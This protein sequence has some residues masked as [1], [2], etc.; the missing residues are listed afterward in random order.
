MS[1]L[2]L[3]ADF[4]EKLLKFGL[5]GL[6]GVLVDF[7]FTWLCKEKLKLH[8]YLANSIGFCMATASNYLL[9]RY[10]TFSVPGQ[11]A[12]FLEFSKFFIIALIGLGLNNVI[13]FLIHEKLKVNFYLAKAIAIGVVAIWNF[14]GNYLYTF[15]G[16]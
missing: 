10:W 15:S 13:L 3:N 4:F 16:S 1:N 2:H 7:S 8:K 6:S 9:N 14:L 12:K 5:V 11:E